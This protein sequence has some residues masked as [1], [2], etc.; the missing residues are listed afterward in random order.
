MEFLY[1]ASA[2][3]LALLSPGPDFFLLTQAA[4]RLPV[5]YGLAV[6]TGIA[7]ANGIYLILAIAG[8]EIVREMPLLMSILRYGGAAYLLYIGYMLLRAPKRQLDDPAEESLLHSR[9]LLKQFSLGF[10]SAILNPKNA[11]FYLS[12]F[13]VMVSDQTGPVLRSLYGV[14][15]VS[16]VLAWDCGIVLFIGRNSIRARLGR[17]IYYV[18]KLAGFALASFGLFLPFC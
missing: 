1:I 17:A 11:I 16:I 13:T 2:H 14:W 12:L 8:L 15:M 7:F 10:S 18:E 9:H 6:S 3:F 5:R 4:L